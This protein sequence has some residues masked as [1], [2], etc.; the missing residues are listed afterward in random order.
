MP[1]TRS[2]TDWFPLGD[3][4]RRPGA[5]FFIRL[6]PDRA[7]ARALRQLEAMG[8]QVTLERV[9]WD[10]DSCS[11]RNFR[12]REPRGPRG[13]RA[14]QGLPLSPVTTGTGDDP[15]EARWAHGRWRTWVGAADRICGSAGR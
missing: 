3:P 2:L 6:H 13:L 15:I 9:G 10:Q 4:L 7:K 12:V 14:R 1:V 5:D 8:Y 11:E